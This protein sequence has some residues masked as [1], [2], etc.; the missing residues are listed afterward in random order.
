MDWLLYVDDVT[1]PGADVYEYP[2]AGGADI[3]GIITGI[4]SAVAAQA[5]AW[6]P[7]TSG[8]TDYSGQAELL[9]AQ[10]VAASSDAAILQQ[11]NIQSQNQQMQLAL[12][13]AQDDGGSSFELDPMM[14]AV[15]GVALVGIVLYLRKK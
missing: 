1:Q 11:Q 8:Y 6:L 9:M 2:G 7:Y 12:A 5:Q 3:G 14:L 4:G 13:A 10:S 15:G